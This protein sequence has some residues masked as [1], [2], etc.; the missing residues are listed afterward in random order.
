M[1]IYLLYVV[2]LKCLKKNYKKADEEGEKMNRK[3]RSNIVLMGLVVCMGLFTGCSNKQ[4]EA[5][6]G[7]KQEGQMVEENASSTG[8]QIETSSISEVV[9]YEEDDYYTAWQDTVTA[10]ITL[11]EE[12]ISAEGEGVKIAGNTLTIEKAGTY[13]LSGTLA[14][15]S[16]IVDA[17]DKGTV[18]LVL[19]GVD[20]SCND[21]AP[22]YVKQA[23]KVVLS[24]EEGTTNRFADGEN[25]ILEDLANDEPNATIYSK[26]DLTING[27]GNLEVIGRYNNAITSKDTL[28]IMEGSVKIEAADDGIMGKDA[29]MIKH[30]DIQITAQGD[31]IKATNDTDETK[32][33]I[34]IEEGEFD[35]VA[36]ADGIQAK[37]NIYIADGTYNIET[38]GGSANAVQKQNTLQMG[39]GQGRNSTPTQIGRAHV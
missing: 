11:K 38:G 20:L 15:G 26:D 2:D 37:T 31:G 35:I 36:A 21:S 30:A 29:V 6:S 1:V 17:T 9:S 22:V 23:S 25:Y 24:L 33:F 16:I 27:K 8:R 3:F 7:V 39:K 5:V 12:G 4:S 13:V 14:D 28:R 19:N 34:A 18:R 10:T 32:G